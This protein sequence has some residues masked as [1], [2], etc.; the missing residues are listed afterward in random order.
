MLDRPEGEAS[1]EHLFARV[2]GIGEKLVRRVVD[3]LDVGSLE[4]LERAAHDG[5]LQEVEGFRRRRVEAVRL[6]LAGMLGR[7]GGRRAERER[8]DI[9]TLFE[10]DEAYR[11]QAEAGKLVQIA[12]R[13][14]KPE[15][16]AW[17]PI[18]HDERGE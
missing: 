16:E 3:R 12:P 1:P 14:F 10:V 6:S 4:E 8:P 2:P 9:E 13:R 11:E 17:L 15:G 5:R 18:L 7:R